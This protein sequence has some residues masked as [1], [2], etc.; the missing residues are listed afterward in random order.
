[1]S[2]KK[3]FAIII[4][5]IFLV[6]CI[7]D[8]F[9]TPR[10]DI[11]Y[12]GEGSGVYE[13]L[14]TGDSFDALKQKLRGDGF[15]IEDASINED[16]AVVKYSQSADADPNEIYANWTYIFGQMVRLAPSS[17]LE[18]NFIICDFDDG[19]TVMVG[20]KTGTIKT[21]LEGKVDAWTFMYYINF[22]PITKGPQI[23][24]GE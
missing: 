6:G 3:L 17:E 10:D 20:A 19:E 11:G 9:D 2:Y 5:S 22:I 18:R 16:V 7:D 13:K 14:Y 15:S 23:W 4:L 12:E 1:M 24:T 8:D 21:F